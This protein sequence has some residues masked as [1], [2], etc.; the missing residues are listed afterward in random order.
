MHTKEMAQRVKTGLCKSEEWSLN[1]Q[2]L[3]KKPGTDT[4]TYSSS[5]WGTGVGEDSQIPKAHWPISL[6]EMA[7]SGSVET[8]SQGNKAVREKDTLFWFPG[9]QHR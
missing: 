3:H 6:A 7:A 9:F 8:L 4:F 1:P 5:T 2:H